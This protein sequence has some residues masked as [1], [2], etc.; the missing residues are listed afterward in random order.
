MLIFASS[1]RI[2]DTVL[3]GVVADIAVGELDRGPGRGVAT[4]TF[5]LDDGRVSLPIPG[6]HKLR[7]GA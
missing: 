5:K 4:F 2:G 3:G 7:V 6:D 1:V